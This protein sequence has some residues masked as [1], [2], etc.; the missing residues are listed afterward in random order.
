MNGPS[1]RLDK[2]LLVN[3]AAGRGAEG[4]RYIPLGLAYVAAELRASGGMAVECLDFQL[5][6]MT[7]EMVLAAAC[8]PRCAMIG[9]RGFAGDYLRV[10]ELAEKIR[11]RARP[12]VPIVLGG[13]LATFS[14]GV[15][16]E[17]TAVDYCVLGEGE[18]TIVALLGHLDDPG[19]VP[20][21]AY[22]GP[23]GTPTRN[24]GGMLPSKPIDEI[25]QPAYDLFDIDA[26]AWR[27]PTVPGVLKFR[28][29][30]SLDIITGR[31]CPFSCKFCGK[32]VKKYRKRSVDAVIAEMT[33]L[34]DTYRIHHFSINDEL[35]Y[36][37][38]TWTPEFCEKVAPLGVTWH[39][40]ARARG[41]RLEDLEQMRAAGCLRINMGVESGSLKSLQVSKKQITP[42]DIRE[43]VALVR[44]AGIHPGTSLI[45]GF[46]GDDAETAR[47]T[48]ALYR[49]LGLPP[50]TF[51][52]LQ[53]YP[54][55]AFFDEFL[56]S[57]L[58]ESHERLLIDLSL[59]EAASG[60][61][62]RNMKQELVVNFTDLSD[63][64]LIALKG[65]A[66]AEM[67]RNW[68]EH[69]KRSRKSAYYLGALRTRIPFR[70][71]IKSLIGGHAPGAGRRGA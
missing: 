30:R 37:F 34:R 49:E 18:T 11:D 41:F 66:E 22:R 64:G 65:R 27:S 58:I 61:P 13:P 8:E 15:V 60:A 40:A 24:P 69:M 55:S 2:V 7:D 26:Y 68:D 43:S 28:K 44:A 17:K 1:P 35:F 63:D 21:I 57:G 4:T 38:K 52:L 3:I 14:Y 71:A 19:A 67:A 32:L 6:H 16:L 9:I 31:G 23:G 59:Q 10:K 53:P 50:K 70:R 5:P 54:G 62:A 29:V 51:G 25:A 39:C 33:Y 46:P 47:E 20:G 36:P 45:L 56:A 42:D 48:V 12:D